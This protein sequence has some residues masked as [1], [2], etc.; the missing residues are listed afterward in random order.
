MIDRLIAYL[1]A[2]PNATADTVGAPFARRDLAV[3]VLLLEVAQ[4]DGRVSMDEI[5][6]IE[7]FVRDRLGV[8]AC[9]ANALVRAARVEF[10]AAL[11]DWVFASEVRE[12]FDVAERCAIV[13]TMWDL[14][15]AD[16]RLGRLEEAMMEHVG[17][18]LD[19]PRAEFEAAREKA[20]GDAQMPR[21]R[22]A[23]RG[24]EDE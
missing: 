16:G 6:A 9:T 21:E 7:K 3:A 22:D 19:V 10:D 24:K 1:D 18:A 12:G 5:A 2:I 15:Y 20:S 23:E 11:E 13:R 8:D 4:S 17:T 14:V